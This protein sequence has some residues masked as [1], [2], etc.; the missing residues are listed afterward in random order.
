MTWMGERPPLEAGCPRGV[1]AAAFG[2]VR[3]ATIC[4]IALRQ[5]A[6]AVS[7]SCHVSD[8]QVEDAVTHI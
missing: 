3:R 5:I 6:S 1:G 8:H 4:A 7:S 2:S